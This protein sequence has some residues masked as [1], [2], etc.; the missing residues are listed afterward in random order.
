MSV[1][2]EGGWLMLVPLVPLSVAVWA[3]RAGTDVNTY[4]LRV[5][6]L[7]GNRVVSW[8]DVE[9]LL[10]DEKGGVAAALINGTVLRLTAVRTADLPR[11][12][13]ASGK[14]PAEAPAV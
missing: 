9:A 14:A 13:E 3:W 7:L 1:A 10:P 5:R 2:A 8:D 4:G 6:A 11:L 12:L